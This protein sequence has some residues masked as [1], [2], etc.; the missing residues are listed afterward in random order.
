MWIGTDD[1]GC[2]P[3]QIE[4]AMWIGMYLTGS[5]HEKF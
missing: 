5:F 3:D 2:S 4:S 1:K